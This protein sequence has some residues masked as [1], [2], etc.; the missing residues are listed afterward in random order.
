MDETAKLVLLPG[1]IY[2]TEVGL[3]QFVK[4]EHDGALIFAQGGFQRYISP[5]REKLMKFLTPRPP[6]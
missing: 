6:S 4:M 1:A 3:M 5:D 2:E